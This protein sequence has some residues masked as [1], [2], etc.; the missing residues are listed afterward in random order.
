M[1][2]RK[3]GKG[4]EASPSKTEGML[5]V[6]EIAILGGGPGKFQTITSLHLFDAS[7]FIAS[8]STAF[9]LTSQPDWQKR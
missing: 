3:S 7:L 1:N 8:L 4:E 9:H 5:P 2:I 6:Q